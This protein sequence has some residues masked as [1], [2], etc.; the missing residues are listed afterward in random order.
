VYTSDEKQPAPSE[1]G[2]IV[3]DDFL[4]LGR[5]PKL[6]LLF[7]DRKFK[8]G[9]KIAVPDKDAQGLFEGGTLK[10]LSVTLREVKKTSDQE[11][12]L[13]DVEVIFE[14]REGH[15]T[16]ITPLKGELSVGLNTAWIERL[17]VAGNIT[18]NGTKPADSTAA[19]KIAH[20]TGTLKY[21]LKVDYK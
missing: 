5:V 11:S 6:S 21:S 3:R 15:L 4:E 20:G 13:F 12:V 18:V 8:V 19:E 1:E 16:Y 2:D 9:E 7:A 17:S 10:N 14:R